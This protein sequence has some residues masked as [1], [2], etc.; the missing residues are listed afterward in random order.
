MIAF[1]FKAN[2][3]LFVAIGLHETQSWPLNMN[4]WFMMWLDEHGWWYWCYSMLVTTMMMD[5]DDKYYGGWRAM[6][7]DDVHRW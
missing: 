3:S 1:G 6:M 7:I 5:V 4:E 2:G